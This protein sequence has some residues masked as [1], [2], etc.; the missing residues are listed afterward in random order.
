MI[1]SRILFQC[2]E[3]TLITH[4]SRDFDARILSNAPSSFYK[5][6]FPESVRLKTGKHGAKIFIYSSIASRSIETSVD[7][8][9]GK[10]SSELAAPSSLDYAWVTAE[11]MKERLTPKYFETIRKLFY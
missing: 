6:K 7:K 11:E 4:K 5:Y 2:G 1:F 3:R 8:R 9:V 10:Q